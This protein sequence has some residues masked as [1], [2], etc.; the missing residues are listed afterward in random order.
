MTS[1]FKFVVFSKVKMQHYLWISLKLT[2][3]LSLSLWSRI[4][5]WYLWDG[6]MTQLFIDSLC[7]H[8]TQLYTVLHLFFL[9]SFAKVQNLKIYVPSRQV[10]TYKSANLQITIQLEKN[11][12]KLTN[13]NH[14]RKHFF[15][16]FSTLCPSITYYILH[17]IWCNNNLADLRQE[18]VSNLLDIF[19]VSM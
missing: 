11:P 19:N 13:N 5:V 10:G 6:K 14:D 17:E 9:F 4:F 2:D 8:R 18:C 16:S 7:C 12:P 3:S 15:T 1:T